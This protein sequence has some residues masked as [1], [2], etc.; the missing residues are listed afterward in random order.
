MIS[1]LKIVS[2]SHNSSLEAWLAFP[3]GATSSLGGMTDVASFY[4]WCVRR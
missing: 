2:S 1:R 4:L 3:F